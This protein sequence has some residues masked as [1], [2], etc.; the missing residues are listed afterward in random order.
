[1]PPGSAGR[2]DLR[3]RDS[4]LSTVPVSSEPSPAPFPKLLL[5]SKNVFRFC[6]FMKVSIHNRHCKF[7]SPR[8][9]SARQRIKNI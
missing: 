3:L 7:G 2:N 4:K 1:M 5:L 6:F 9:E 8:A